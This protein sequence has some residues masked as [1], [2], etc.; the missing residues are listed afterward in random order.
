MFIGFFLSLFLALKST[1]VFS[2]DRDYQGPCWKV[3]APVIQWA[4]KEG[5]KTLSQE[6]RWRFLFEK[7]HTLI[8][9]SG[10]IGETEGKAIAWELEFL[11]YQ[12][13]FTQARVSWESK[14]GLFRFDP[15]HLCS[16][17]YHS[18]TALEGH[19][20]NIFPLQTG[21]IFQQH[22]LDYVFYSLRR[23]P[24]ISGGATLS[25][26]G[27]LLFSWKQQKPWRAQFWMENTGSGQGGGMRFENDHFLLLNDLLSFHATGTH[28]PK[29]HKTFGN[30][31]SASFQYTI[32]FRW[33]LIYFESRY[34]HYEQQLLGS[35]SGGAYRYRGRRYE[36]IFTLS[37]MLFFRFNRQFTAFAQGERRSIEGW[38]EDY[39]L[40]ERVQQAYAGSVGVRYQGTVGERAFFL[41]STYRQSDI[42]SQTLLTTVSY[43]QPWAFSQGILSYQ[44]DWRGQWHLGDLPEQDFFVLTGPNG[45]R[46]FGRMAEVGSDSGWVW[47]QDLYW[48]PRQ[49]M[50]C[51]FYGGLDIGSL[52]GSL[53][54]ERGGDYL[55]G[56]GVGVKGEGSL[57]SYS[58]SLGHVLKKPK[59]LSVSP[60]TVLWKVQINI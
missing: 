13:G 1:F 8:Q 7:I 29:Q 59:T 15:G 49:L 56:M 19:Y 14:D 17:S 24:S 5:K 48:R 25:P 22:T 40:Q 52:A 26:E 36:Q 27:D 46:G 21:D 38:L 34:H 58:F 44:T 43:Q 33:W 18:D 11:L 30:N 12:A 10:C 6:K 23:T 9:E 51:T 53:F 54:P 31:Q 60:V 28:Y 4:Q 57:W 3:Q 37:R 41:E 45:V 50:A 47:S 16:I 42:L 2:S 39:P 55:M 35:S 20:W 32:P